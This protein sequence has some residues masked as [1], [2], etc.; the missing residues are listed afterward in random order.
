[1][2]RESEFLRHVDEELRKFYKSEYY[3]KRV[4]ILIFCRVGDNCLATVI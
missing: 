2:M 1:M 4:I 3:E